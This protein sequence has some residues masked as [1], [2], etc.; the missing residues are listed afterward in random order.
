MRSDSMGRRQGN[1]TFRALPG[2]PLVCLHFA[3]NDLSLIINSLNENS[4]VN[5]PSGSWK[6][7]KSGANWSKVQIM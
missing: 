7:P 5:Y 3:D 4:L 6:T 1:P 2:L